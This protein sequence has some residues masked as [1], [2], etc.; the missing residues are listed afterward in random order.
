MPHCQ[1]CRSSYSGRYEAHIS[2]KTHL[3]VL[4]QIQ[5]E[6]KTALERRNELRIHASFLE[7]PNSQSPIL[8]IEMNWAAI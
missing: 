6:K 7:V 5:T 1:T 3:K 4:I 8:E 2:N